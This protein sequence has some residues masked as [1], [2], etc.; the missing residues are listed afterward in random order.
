MKVKEDFKKEEQI[1]EAIRMIPRKEIINE[2]E[3]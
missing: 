1:E 2:I 3:N